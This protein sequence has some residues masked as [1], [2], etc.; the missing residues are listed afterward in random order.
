MFGNLQI[1]PYGVLLATA[2]GLGIGLGIYNGKKLG[3]NSD[4]II[5][6]ALWFVISAIVGSRVLYILLYP[7]QF[8]SFISY[9]D[10]TKGGLVFYG[11]FLFT[12]VTVIGYAFYNKIDLRDL[13]DLIA[14][15]LSLGHSIGRIGCF[16]NGCCYG[17]PT[18]CF[19]GIVF[20]NLHD[21]L[22]RHPT[23]LYESFFLM[24]TFLISLWLLGKRCQQKNIIINRFKAFK[25]IV[26]G[27]Y[28]LSYSI[29]RFFIEYF[30]DD[31]R[32][33]VFT[34]LN[35][36]ISQLI[37]VFLLFFAFVWLVLCYNLSRTKN[38]E[39]Q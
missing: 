27:Y 12:L 7:D 30:R 37:S 16:I 36:S 33:G 32:G 23:Q 24:I 3:F 38:Q 4:Q 5:D 11:G 17:K 22:P 21:N 34:R 6:L 15:S 18:E 31:D 8:K 26:W 19:C 14:P 28:L 13:G 10:I 9:I 2:F 39:S 25:G 29:W 20:K 35:L 1:Q